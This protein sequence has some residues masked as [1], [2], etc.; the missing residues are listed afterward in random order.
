MEYEYIISERLDT[1]APAK[2]AANAM[3]RMK[4]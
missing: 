1:T 3:V 4:P 2:G